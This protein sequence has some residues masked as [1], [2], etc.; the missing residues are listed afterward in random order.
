[1]GGTLPGGVRASRP[2]AARL[3]R[4]PRRGRPGR[5]LGH[6]RLVARAPRGAL[7][8]GSRPEPAR[9]DRP[10]RHRPRAPPADRPLHAQ[11]GPVRHPR[12]RGVRVSVRRDPGRRRPRDDRLDDRLARAAVPGRARLGGSGPG[13]DPS[14]AG[15][16]EHAN[17]RVRRDPGGWDRQRGGPAVTPDPTWSDYY[18]ANDGRQPRDVLLEVLS[19][20]ADPGDAV[21]LGC[22]SGIDTLAMLS[23]GWRVF[24]VDAEEEAIDRLRGRVP[25]ELHGHLRTAVAPMEEVELPRAD[26][27]LPSFSLF[28]CDPGGFAD[29]W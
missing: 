9:D 14:P 13:T 11:R 25:L 22:G 4:R 16:K 21:D 27:L 15:A 12:I 5:V 17:Q 19:T 8:L 6:A 1:E 29:L 10:L 7:R 26:L 24:A 23:R 20:R 2:D 3:A 18:E 28:F